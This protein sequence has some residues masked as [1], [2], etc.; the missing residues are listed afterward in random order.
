M[1]SI[2]ITLLV[3]I[4]QINIAVAQSTINNQKIER[5][6]NQMKSSP[7]SLPE[8]NA[9]IRIAVGRTLKYSHSVHSSVGYS[10]RVEYDKSAFEMKYSTRYDNSDA[11]NS[12]VCGADSAI[13]TTTF[14]SL[15]KGEYIIKVIHE[16]RGDVENVL[17][18]KIIVK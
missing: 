11:V 3:F 2:I 9:V 7:I 1:K 8:K 4:L 12:G 6:I 14:K 5:V 15:K 18:Y 16:F 17:T 10:Y 13:E